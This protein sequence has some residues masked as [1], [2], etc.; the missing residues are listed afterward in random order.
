[1]KAQIT[2]ATALATLSLAALT[3]GSAEA[4][5]V[6]RN[7]YQMV[8]GSPLATPYCQDNLVGAVARERGIKVSDAEIRDNPNTKRYVCQL[9]GR[10]NRTYMA[11]INAYGARRGF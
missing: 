3:A 9:I 5:I 7:G 6:C 10:D 4:K 11:C 1:M 2:L 8:N